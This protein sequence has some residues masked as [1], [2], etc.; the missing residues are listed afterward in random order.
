MTQTQEDI[1]MLQRHE[2]II[3]RDILPRLDRFEKAQLDFSNQVESIKSS[4]T[5]LELTVMKDGQ[6]TRG[7][8][9]KFVDHFFALDKDK[10]V[11]NERITLKRF[12]SKEKIALAVIAAIA[13]SGGL[14]AAIATLIEAVK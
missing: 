6:E 3:H 5:G 7:L 13:G 11:T 2:E 10:I 12:S 8:L 14:I 9:N 4:Q 1:N